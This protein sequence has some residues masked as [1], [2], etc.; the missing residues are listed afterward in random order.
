MQVAIETVFRLQPHMH[1]VLDLSS[2]W[3]KYPAT[4][5]LLVDASS[6]PCKRIMENPQESALEAVRQK[7]DAFKEVDEVWQSDREV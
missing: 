7:W 6:P 2:H 1:V 4:W 3:G 5:T